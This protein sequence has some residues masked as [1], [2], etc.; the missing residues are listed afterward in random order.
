MF[1]T[2]DLNNLNLNVNSNTSVL[3]SGGLYSYLGENLPS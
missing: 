2:T 3:L 1:N